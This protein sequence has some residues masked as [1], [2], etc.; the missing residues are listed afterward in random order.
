VLLN[1]ANVIGM[2]HHHN[3]GQMLTPLSYRKMNAVH[4]AGQPAYTVWPIDFDLL[5]TG[6]QFNQ[7]LAQINGWQNVQ[8][9]LVTFDGEA[10]LMMNHITK[11]K[12][13]VRKDTK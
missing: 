4:F 1:I 10:Y 6:N 3:P 13:I 5:Q 7:R 2:A 12:N 8:H 11:S 9:V